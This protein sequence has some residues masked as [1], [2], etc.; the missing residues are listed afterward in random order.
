MQRMHLIIPLSV[1]TL[2]SPSETRDL[3]VGWQEFSVPAQREP[4]GSSLEGFG[5][6]GLLFGGPG[7]VRQLTDLNASYQILL[8]TAAIP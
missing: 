7:L 6:V 3:M 8:I 1:P 4:Q 5:A 2:W